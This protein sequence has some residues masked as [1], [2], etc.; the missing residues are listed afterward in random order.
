M[1]ESE[2]SVDVEEEFIKTNSEE[3]KYDYLQLSLIELNERIKQSL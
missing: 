1:K 2:V 3:I